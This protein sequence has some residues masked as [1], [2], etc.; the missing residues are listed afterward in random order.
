MLPWST[1]EFRVIFSATKWRS[2]HLS[3]QLII[4]FTIFYARINEFHALIPR[5]IYQIHVFS[6]TWLKKFAIFTLN[7]LNNFE[8]FLWRLANIDI[9]PQPTSR[10]YF[11]DRRISWFFFMKP[12]NEFRNIFPQSIEEFRDCSLR[13]TNKFHDRF[14]TTEERIL[15]F[16]LTTYWRI[17][18]FCDRLMNFMIFFVK[19]TKGFCEFFSRCTY[20]WRLFYDQLMNFVKPRK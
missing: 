13:P 5:Q 3:P 2:Y 16:F 8:I 20:V 14:H 10:I 9:V 1:D 12:R 17:S 4:N 18:R 15:H 7:L 19:P 11:C 6:H